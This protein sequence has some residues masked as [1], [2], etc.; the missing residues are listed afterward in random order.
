M[1]RKNI[2]ISIAILKSLNDAEYHTITATT[3]MVAKYFKLK[4]NDMDEI[5]DSRKTNTVGASFS[6]KKIYTQTQLMVGQLRKSKFI[7]DFPGMKGKGIF[8]ITNKGS[9][10]LTKNSSE[11]KK[12]INFELTKR[13]NL[14]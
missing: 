3:L 2:D 12:I 14:K 10:L 8:A 9:L 6:N 7:Q 4:N 1:E 13:K 11:R 5:Y